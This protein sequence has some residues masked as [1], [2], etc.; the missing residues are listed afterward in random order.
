MNDDPILKGRACGTCTLCCKLMGVPELEKPRGT[1]CTHCKVG[2]GCGIYSDRPEVCRGFYCTYLLSPMLGEHWYPGRCK[3]VVVVES[4]YGGQRVTIHVDPGRPKAWREQPHYADLKRWATA[5]A[6][7]LRQ[8]VVSI[9]DRLIV[10]LPN[11]DVDL[12]VVGLDERVVLS[13][14]PE[15]GRLR[16]RAFKLR[17]DDPRLAG[18]RQGEINESG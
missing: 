12:G 5:A 14:V 8:V 11:E 7:D 17:A 4:E 16:L 6:R 10:I 1:W 2:Q 9:G 3:M 18:A 15:N 13:E